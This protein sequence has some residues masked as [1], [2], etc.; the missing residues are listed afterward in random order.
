MGPAFK[1]A[2]VPAVCRRPCSALKGAHDRFSFLEFKL[3]VRRCGQRAGK[4]C[5]SL[6]LRGFP[7]DTS[8]QLVQ[9]VL[10][11]SKISIT[12]LASFQTKKERNTDEKH[13]ANLLCSG[14]RKGMG[15]KVGEIKTTA[16]SDCPESEQ[17]RLGVEDR[18]QPAAFLP[19]RAWNACGWTS[20]EHKNGFQNMPCGTFLKS[21]LVT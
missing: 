18:S 1:A 21:A 2:H 19:G 9:K 12:A 8:C 6:R 16:R 15:C 11:P 17:Q 14:D 4:S 20:K 7:S 3:F 10:I 5:G 13:T